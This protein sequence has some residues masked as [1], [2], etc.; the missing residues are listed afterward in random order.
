[1]WRRSRNNYRDEWIAW[2]VIIAVVIYAII[3][4]IFWLLVIS[5]VVLAIYLAYELSL[6]VDDIWL[7]ISIWIITATWILLWGSEILHNYWKINKSILDYSVETAT[8]LR[9]KTNKKWNI[10]VESDYW[11]LIETKN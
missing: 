6:L 8:E 4:A 7:K 2:V 3:T 11:T 10:K 9:L 1:M 5:A